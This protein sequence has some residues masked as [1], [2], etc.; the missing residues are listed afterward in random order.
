[1]MRY[2]PTRLGMARA[3]TGWVASSAIDKVSVDDADQD[4]G[5]EP[6]GSVMRIPDRPAPALFSR[7]AAENGQMARPRTGSHPRPR[8]VPGRFPRARPRM[9]CR[10]RRA[11]G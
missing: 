1:M 3:E 9:P 4:T 6:E 5:R 7:G 10:P 2:L 8:P 11:A